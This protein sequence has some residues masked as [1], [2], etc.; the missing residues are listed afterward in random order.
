MRLLAFTLLSC[1]SANAGLMVNQSSLN[2]PIQTVVTDASTTPTTNQTIVAAGWN[3]VRVWTSSQPLTEPYFYL[4]SSRNGGTPDRIQV[5]RDS[6]RIISATSGDILSFGTA[7]NLS[8]VTS[9]TLYVTPMYAPTTTESAAGVTGTANCDDGVPPLWSPSG[10][11]VALPANA[12]CFQ[13]NFNG[14]FRK[15]F[16]TESI[17]GKTWTPARFVETELAR[18]TV[19]RTSYRFI[20]LATVGGSTLS[21]TAPPGTLIGGTSHRMSLPFTAITGTSY[22]V[23]NLTSFLAAVALAVKGDEIVMSSGTYQQVTPLVTTNFT[24]NIAAGNKGSEGILIRSASGNH[25][26]VI[27]SGTLTNSG[28]WSINNTTGTG[29]AGIKDISFDY[30]TT[31]SVLST[32]GGKWLFQNVRILGPNTNGADLWELGITTTDTIT[33]DALYCI[34]TNSYSDCINGA[35]GTGNAGS[36]VRFFECTGAV[37]GTNANDQIATTHGGLAFEMYGCNWSDAKLNTVAPDAITSPMYLLY[38][39]LGYGTRADGIQNAS[40]IHGCNI[41]CTNGDGI[42][43]SYTTQSIFTGVGFAASSTLFRNQTGHYG[44]LVTCPVGRAFFDSIDNREHRGNIVIRGG[45][46]FR[47][48]NSTSN[49]IVAMIGNTCISNGIALSFGDVNITQ[50][51]TNN[52]CRVSGTSINC[53]AGED[54][55]MQKSSGVYDPTVS[56]NYTPVASDITGVDAALDASFFPTAAGNCDGNGDTNAVNFAGS[57]D[58]AGFPRVY[59]RTRISR[60]ARELPAVYTGAVLLPDLW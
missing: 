28:T 15:V 54:A 55:R 51:V 21:I 56:V 23:S 34:C 52:A 24:A 37:A 5:Y 1:L 3:G 44:N 8:N 33:S 57:S 47:T 17:D 36:R 25:D 4:Y 32:Y 2:H 42:G 48:S 30:S 29:Y 45:E 40:L 14:A 49:S 46:A 35:G 7:D 20:A 16:I 11:H 59:L 43:S 10:W 39:D 53:T 27:I 41:T 18:N 12:R 31:A 60:G 26:D 38:C 6:G 9:R 19:I 22:S 50:W 13:I 58:F